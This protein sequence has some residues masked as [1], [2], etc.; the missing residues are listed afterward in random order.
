MSAQCVPETVRHCLGHGAGAVATMPG[1]S[2]ECVPYPE[3]CRSWVRV[4]WAGGNTTTDSRPYAPGELMMWL[5]CIL[6]VRDLNVDRLAWEP[7]FTAEPSA[8]NPF[9]GRAAS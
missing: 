9:V 4:R 7:D 5:L 1:C 2:V 6:A 3:S 8:R